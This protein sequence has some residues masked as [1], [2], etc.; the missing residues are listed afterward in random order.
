MNHSVVTSIK[1]VEEIKALAVGLSAKDHHNDQVIS[2]LAEYLIIRVSGL[3][4]VS[5]KAILLDRAKTT[6]NDL[7]VLTFI[8][9]QLSRH[10]DLN[11]GKI[12]TLV[13]HFSSDWGAA[14][15]RDIVGPMKESI[16]SVVLLRN[17]L[18]HGGDITISF[19]TALEHN[20]HVLDAMQT[21]ASIC[22]PEAESWFVP[23]VALLVIDVQ[24]R[25]FQESTPVYRADQLLRNINVLVDN[26]HAAG[27]PVF[28][29]Q[30]STKTTLIEGSG[31]WQLHPSLR[32]QTTDHFI[33]K[34]HSNAFEDTP[35][36]SELD[37]LHASGV[38]VAGLITDG[39]VQATCKGA[40]ALGYDVTLMEDAHS[41]NSPDS[42]QVIDKWNAKLGRR[43]VR[44]QATSAVDFR[45]AGA[46]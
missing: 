1:H 24:R 12:C 7:P 14:V 43:I 44:L 37:T 31:A 10:W 35:L 29:I 36:E 17:T 26:A 15:K 9:Y 11:H 21:L 16:N 2:R 25:L 39:C 8:E 6:T 46:K 27:V 3:I 30:H 32:P 5:V 41:T 23:P 33:H 19:S 18:A 34:H 20:R 38:L 22:N 42:E 4:E 28:Y 40:R 13:E 45:A